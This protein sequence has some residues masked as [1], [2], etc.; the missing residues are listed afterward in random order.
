MR[1]LVAVVVMVVVVVTASVAYGQSCTLWMN[2]YT[3]EREV[4]E[5]N[6][7]CWWPHTPPFGNWGVES[8]YGPRIDG[9]QFPGWNTDGDWH[10]WNSCTTGRGGKF[11]KAEYMPPGWEEGDPQESSIGQSWVVGY[12]WHRSGDWCRM[13]NRW[14]VLDDP[15]LHLYELDKND[16][17]EFVATLNFP[18][19]WALM[20][21]RSAHV[22]IC[23][24]E[25][26]WTDSYGSFPADAETK[27]SFTAWVWGYTP[28]QEAIGGAP[29]SG[30]PTLPRAGLLDGAV[31]DASTNRPTPNGHVLVIVNTPTVM[32][33]HGFDAVSGA[34]SFPELP[35]GE[36]TLVARAEGYSP[37]WT[38]FE[39]RGDRTEN[40][41]LKLAAILAGVVVDT[42]GAPVAGAAVNVD[43]SDEAGA[44]GLLDGMVGG[45]P[46]TNADGEFLLRGVIADTTLTLDVRLPSGVVIDDAVTVSTEAGM[47]Q[48]GISIEI[49]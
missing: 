38:T 8:I 1:R 26:S 44:N 2:L 12:A 28:G 46:I 41:R 31:I 17:D 14:Y 33:H 3:Q 11:R 25:S 18:D 37:A 6:T 10:Q 9:Y 36:V 47:M 30:P 21:C 16:D 32:S 40:M 5:A 35:A 19:L 29:I 49:P 42:S 13:H 27:V 48:Q 45:Q 23:D 4:W 43:Y 20:T 22:T 24:G 7:E 15:A 39:I 34:F